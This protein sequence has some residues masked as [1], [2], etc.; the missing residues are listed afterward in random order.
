MLNKKLIMLAIF[1]VSLLAVSAVSAADNVT[2]EIVSVEETTLDVVKETDDV[3]SAGDDNQVISAIE[4][5]VG[6]FNDLVNEINVVEEGGILNLT[7]DYK[8]VDGS[9]LGIKIN[10]PITIDGNGHTLNGNNMARIFD[11]N[12]IDVVLKNIRLTNSNFTKINTYGAI[13][14]NG[15]NG[16]GYNLSF[17]NNSANVCGALYINCK[18]LTI[19]NSNFINNNAFTGGGGAIMMRGEKTSIKNCLFEN[20][21]VFTAGEYGKGG[22][23][24]FTSGLYSEIS[25][26]TFIN[27]SATSYGGA[28]YLGSIYAKINNCLFENN[29]AKYGGAIVVNGHSNKISGSFINNT[30]MYGGAIYVQKNDVQITD[31]LFRNNSNGYS[32]Y[33]INNNLTID[34]CKFMGDYLFYEY[35]NSQFKHILRN[36]IFYNDDNPIIYNANVMTLEQANN[37]FYRLTQTTEENSNNNSNNVNEDNSKWENMESHVSVMDLSYI[38]SGNVVTSSNYV[39]ITQYGDNNQFIDVIMKTAFTGSIQI[40]YDTY[41]HLTNKALDYSDSFMGIDSEEYF[42]KNEGIQTF[43]Y[44]LSSWDPGLVYMT[45]KKDSNPFAYVNFYITKGITAYNVVKS[46]GESEKFIVYIFDD[47]NNPVKGETVVAF[48]N[49]LKY[50]EKTN[51]SGIASFSLNLKP[52]EY[53]VVAVQ[54]KNTVKSKVKIISSTK[55]SVNDISKVYGTTKDWIITLKDSGDNPINDKLVT[56]LLNGETYNKKTDKYG[57]IA[58]SIPTDLVPNTYTATFTFAGDNIYLKNSTKAKLKIS[59]SPSKLTV[60][61]INNVYKNAKSWIITLNDGDGNPLTNKRISIV[62][63][64]VT[65]NKNTNGNGQATLAIPTKLVP[66]T[67]TATFSFAGDTGYNKASTKAKLTVSKSTP[68]ITANIKTFK[69]TDKTKKYAITLKDNNDKAIKNVNVNLKVNGKTYTAKTNSKGQATFK[70]TKLT[71]K[72]TY[73]ATIKWAGTKNFKS[74]SKKVKITVTKPATSKSVTLKIIY[75][76]TVFPKKKLSNGD[77]IMTTYEKYSGRQWGPGVY[78]TVTH[79]VGLLESKNTKLVKCTVWFKNSAGKVITK[80][81]TKFQSNWFIKV[82]LQKGYTPYKAQIWYKNRM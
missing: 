26:S 36:S 8:Y 56:I 45:V 71:K 9:T 1:L 43:S 81:S 30:A 50:A 72:G 67:Y 73:T 12:S 58:F 70:I 53:D 17:I 80:S 31:S 35:K 46:Y 10:K 24:L 74:T 6:T 61:N 66:N 23:I 77:V 2:K 55:L 27:N 57:Q 15:D 59:K 19:S 14:W 79:G 44:D 20:N 38:D 28:I 82:S 63:N 69:T 54:D 18:N 11:I 78:A 47:K 37:K 68:K 13:S 16:Y 52:G 39:T 42:Y 4:S 22:A 75:S 29:S 48:I 34:N 64:G 7:K 62:L 5:N 3:D 60:K 40:T 32:I 41:N 33:C 65:Y 25:N 21:N 49:G 51:S 76:D